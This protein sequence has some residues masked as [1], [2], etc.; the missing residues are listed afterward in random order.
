[1]PD[2][3]LCVVWFLYCKQISNVLLQRSNNQKFVIHALNFI[4][5]LNLVL[6]CRCCC[7][8]AQAWVCYVQSGGNVSAYRTKQLLFCG[9]WH[10][11][12]VWRWHQ[13]TK[14][15]KLNGISCN[16]NTIP[17]WYDIFEYTLS[18]EWL[19]VVLENKCQTT[20]TDSTIQFDWPCKFYGNSVY[21]SANRK[22]MQFFV[23]ILHQ[24]CEQILHATILI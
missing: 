13:L 20:S 15:M 23:K 12:R 10:A 3:L 21:H 9:V 7:C 18:M 5:Q 22:F 14:P 11:Y 17:Q 8:C 4:K 2:L 19:V 16:T 1:M 6:R 24:I